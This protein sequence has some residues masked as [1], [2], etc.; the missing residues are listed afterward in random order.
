[1]AFSTIYT[2]QPMTGTANDDFI[3]AYAGSTGT[4]ANSVNAGAGDDWV[5][6]DSTDTWIP[7][8]SYNNSSIG[9]AFSFD[10]LSSTW[11]T[12]ENP[13][14]G[15]AAVP[16]AT[17]IVEA[18]IGQAEY[19]KVNVG[20]GETIT[21]DIDFATATAIGMPAADL[22]IELLDGSGNV[23]ASVDD[24]LVSDG[25]LGS[26]PAS[27]GSLASY[28]PYL[29]YTAGAAATYYIRVRPFGGG[30]SGTFTEN[31]TFILNLSVTGHVTS[32]NAVPG[33]DV[34][35][36]EDG[37][38]TL[39]GQGGDDIINGGAGNDLIHGGSGV[40]TLR[41]GADNDTIHGGEGTEENVYGDDGNDILVSGGEGHYWGGDGDDLIIAGLT[42]G[43]NEFLDGGAG[44]DTVDT[45]SWNGT[46][47][48]NLA[49][50]TT[51][52]G[53]VF[54]SFENVITGG[55]ADIITGTSGANVIRTGAGT[56]T[57]NAG[58]GDDI[59]EGGDGADTMHGE[60]GI[61]TL[62]YSKAIGAVTVSLG[63]GTGS[64][65]HA[66]GDVFTGFE[67]VIGSSQSDTLT[68]DAGANTLVGGFGNDTLDGSTGTDR[69]EGGLGNDTYGVDS[70]GDVIIEL[71]NAGLDQVFSSANITLS[72]HVENLTLLGAQ[73]LTGTGNDQ[74]NVLV[75]ND[76][77]NI[78]SGLIGNDTL[79]GQG[80]NDTLVGGLGDDIYWID[81]G[82]S[83]VEAAN[84]GTDTINVALASFTL[85][86]NFENLEFTGAGDFVGTGNNAANLIRGGAGND[87]LSGGRGVDTLV[88]RAGDDTYIVDNP[89]D[90]VDESTGSGIDTVRTSA[91][92]TLGTGVENLVQLGSAVT[93]GNGNDLANT[94]TGNNVANRLNGL[95]GDDTIS[96]GNGADTL[97]GGEGNDN[98]TGG[99]DNDILLGEAGND[100]LDGG[101]GDDEMR[102]GIGDDTYIVNS[103]GDTVSEAGGGGTDLV[104]SSIAWTL[105]NGLEN[106]VITTSQGVAGTGNAGN[107]G[108]TGGNGANALSGL[109]GVDYLSGNGG[110]DT[111]N[112]GAGADVLTGGTGND[113]F[114]FAAGQAQGDMVMDFTGNGA[115][116]GDTIRFTGYGTAAAGATFI[117]L[118]ASNWRVTSANGGITEVITFT[119]MAAVHASDYVFV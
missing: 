64:G 80:G 63:N 48:V 21:V 84:Q 43:V 103:A 114:V 73:A 19:F 92:H 8:Q 100:T 109:G 107:N 106:L 89:G 91:S 102:G 66:T 13:M 99:G 20:A 67:N 29:V 6:G 110:A 82:D 119:N 101:A 3:I 5:L 54:T 74:N 25:G 94:M 111:L 83:L 97:K 24:S 62:D 49:A 118:D 113:V 7:N 51:N 90:V 41:G 18:T 45:T 78:L 56:D 23:L 98:I 65:S 87:T 69:L 93:T 9:E 117:Q 75:G 16:H 39:F 14:F 58:D 12:G 52:F 30:Q 96:G 35:N 55:G 10:N 108:L 81:L 37:D 77:A 47:E 32:A 4:N 76:A 61:D 38:D 70:E 53:E 44:I 59:V 88:G 17:A 1:M 116:T 34:L 50:G 31:N 85:A 15:N 27:P 46:Y 42:S 72:T 22:V 57:V 28:D 33:N 95:G 60:G 112:G 104:A 79:M 36:G 26:F 2:G 71:L 86:N 105:G 68:G 40:D 11:T 115:S